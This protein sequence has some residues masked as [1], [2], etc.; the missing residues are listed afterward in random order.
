MDDYFTPID[1]YCERLDAS[2]FS[3]PMNALSNGAFLI[4]AFALWRQWRGSKDVEALWLIRL[5]ALV[6]VGSL[7][8]HLFANKL[9]MLADVIPI[10][11]FVVIYIWVSFRRFL[12]WTPRAALI[13]IGVFFLASYLMPLA[14][15]AYRMNGSISY[16]P[17]L[18]VLLV[19]FGLL[20][21]RGHAQASRICTGALLFMVSLGLR[22]ADMQW[23]EGWPVGTHFFWHMLNGVLLYLLVSAVMRAPRKHK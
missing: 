10:A 16:L 12:G 2:L 3:E 11:L 21:A 9:T 23:C 19:L 6:G 18:L 14:P 15:E 4:A 1:N 13:M 17:C 7:L 20:N 8:F 22:S 5:V